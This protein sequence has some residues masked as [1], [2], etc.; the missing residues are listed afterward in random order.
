M[1][2]VFAP[3]FVFGSKGVLCG[4]QGHYDE[5]SMLDS[6]ADLSDCTPTTCSTDSTPL[7]VSPRLLTS[8]PTSRP[9]SVS[10]RGSPSQHQLCASPRNLWSP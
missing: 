10:S 2:C 6:D 4:G 7:A 3:P 9:S 5:P 1:V 8:F